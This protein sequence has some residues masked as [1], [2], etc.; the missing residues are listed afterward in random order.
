MGSEWVAQWTKRARKARLTG[1]RITSL[2]LEE[3]LTNEE[4]E[5]NMKQEQ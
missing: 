4:K 2:S 5:R 1:I 3:K